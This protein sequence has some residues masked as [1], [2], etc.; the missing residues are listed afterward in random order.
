MTLARAWF[1]SKSE[2][3]HGEWVVSFD[4]RQLTV[5]GV[6]PAS[7][8]NVALPTRVHEPFALTLTLGFSQ[9]RRR[10]ALPEQRPLASD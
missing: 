6:V 1:R 5:T 8:T 2:H 7:L 10:H 4:M 9:F 3:P